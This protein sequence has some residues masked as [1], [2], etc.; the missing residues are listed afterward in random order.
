M[1]L[2]HSPD[3]PPAAACLLPLGG[4][5]GIRLMVPPPPP[6]TIYRVAVLYSPR[7]TSGDSSVCCA[8]EPFVFLYAPL[9]FHLFFRGFGQ[10]NLVEVD[11]RH[12]L[13]DP[14][15]HLS[16]RLKESFLTSPNSSKIE[17]NIQVPT[18]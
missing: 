5:W 2:K 7:T 6:G 4:A 13:Y 12:I 14:R 3:K 9:V 17:V 11:V 10:E 8:G 16:L 18:A 1:K 15:F